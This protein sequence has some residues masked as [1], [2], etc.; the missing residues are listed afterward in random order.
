MISFLLLFNSCKRCQT[1]DCYKNGT[2]YEEHEC[3]KSTDHDDYFRYWQNQ[4]IEENNYDRCNC[5]YD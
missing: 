3:A 2:V 4:I 5:A 1:C